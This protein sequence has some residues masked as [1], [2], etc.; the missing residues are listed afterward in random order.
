MTDLHIS[1][2]CLLLSTIVQNTFA[3]SCE[4]K[5]RLAD[6]QDIIKNQ[7]KLIGDMR[8][9]IE[10]QKNTIENMTEFIE[11]QT[12]VTDDLKKKIENL[13]TGIKHVYL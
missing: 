1:V 2:I 9:V 13:S 12:T 5:I 8:Q 10:D 11:H 6:L 3:A 7:K 4:N